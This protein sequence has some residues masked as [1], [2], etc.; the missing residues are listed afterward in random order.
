MKF[1]ELTDEVIDKARAIYTDKTISWDNRMK[2]LTELFG[3][4]ERT[5]RKWCS[6]KLG[7]KEKQEIEEYYRR[8]NT[9]NGG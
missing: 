4:S 3:R 1:K 5:V 7:F 8:Q 2:E 6:E 9:E